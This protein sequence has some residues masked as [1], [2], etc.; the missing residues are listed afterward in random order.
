MFEILLPKTFPITTSDSFWRLAIILTTTSGKEVPIDTSVKPITSSEMPNR[1]A[2]PEELST[3]KLP[4]CHN[5]KQ[6]IQNKKL[7]NMELQYSLCL[8]DLVM[9]YKLDYNSVDFYTEIKDKKN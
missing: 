4:P 3:T 8:I 5:K 9:L 2:I 7:S 1:R 6:P